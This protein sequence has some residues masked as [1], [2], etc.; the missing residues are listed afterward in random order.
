MNYFNKEELSLE[1]YSK[2]KSAL[3]RSFSRNRMD[4]TISLREHN[5]SLEALVNLNLDENYLSS[6]YPELLNSNKRSKLSSSIY[7]FLNKKDTYSTLFNLKL[8]EIASSEYE[9]LDEEL[10]RS[11]FYAGLLKHLKSEPFYKIDFYSKTNKEILEPKLKLTDG[12]DIRFNFGDKIYN[13]FISKRDEIAFKVSKNYITKSI[14]HLNHSDRDAWNNSESIKDQ[15]HR[16]YANEVSYLS[17][18]ISNIKSGNKKNVGLPYD[19]IEFYNELLD[20][21]ITFDY[22][23]KIKEKPVSEFEKTFNRL[24]N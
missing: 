2:V 20:D 12:S 15:I 13:D 11:D 24:Y 21:F 7:N 8:A 23:K 19:N 3:D 9:N 1:D 6:L 18:A 10:F 16:F 14:T 17:K 5:F 4:R 22:E